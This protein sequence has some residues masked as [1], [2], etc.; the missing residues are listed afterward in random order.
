MTYRQGKRSKDEKK[1]DIA[2]RARMFLLT[3][4]GW[5]LLLSIKSSSLQSLVNVYKCI[6]IEDED[7]DEG[8]GGE[9]EEEK[10]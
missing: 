2:T 10:T 6:Y 1:N 7:E 3:S 5:P 4:D 8:G 9:D